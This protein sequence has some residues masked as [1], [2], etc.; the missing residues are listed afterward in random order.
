MKYADLALAVWAILT[1]FEIPAR[2][3]TFRTIRWGDNIKPLATGDWLIRLGDPGSPGTKHKFPE[4][5]HQLIAQAHLHWK[6]ARRSGRQASL[7]MQ[8]CHPDI[9]GRCNT[10]P[11]EIHWFIES[12]GERRRES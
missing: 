5:Q 4:L 6:L 9:R 12:G 11:S 10:A 1:I 2:A 7:G 3:R 8:A